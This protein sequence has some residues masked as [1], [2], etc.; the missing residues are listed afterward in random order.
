M[1]T[2]VTPAARVRPSGWWYLLVPVI[3]L[4]GFANAILVGIEEV[5]GVADSFD[6]L[7]R[8]GRGSVTLEQG[9]QATLWAT[10]DD[11]RSSESLRR[12]DATVV[13]TGPD[14]AVRPF[15]RSRSTTTF[16]VGEDAGIAVGTFQGADA[17]RYDVRVTWDDATEPGTRPVAAVGSFDISA[18]VGRVLRPILLALLA[19]AGLVV[20]LLVLRGRS[21]RRNAARELYASHDPTSSSAQGPISFS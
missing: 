18:V 4:V 2:I 15:E 12:P 21:K 16:S 11:G 13:V 1:S 14:D 19:A 5:G 8:D 17:G 20:A 10:W 7:G 9:E 3:L 6:R